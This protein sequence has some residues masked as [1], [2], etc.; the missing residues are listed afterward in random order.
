METSKKIIVDTIGADKG[1]GEVVG[2]ALTALNKRNDFT[3]VL[4]GPENEINSHLSSTDLKRTNL[5]ILNAEEKITNED[6]PVMA[7]R[8]K[9]NSSMVLSLEALKEGRADGFLSCGSTGALLAGGTLKVGRIKG[10]K[11]AAL[12]LVVPGLNK[13]TI[14]L[15]VGANADCTPLWLEQFALMGESYSELLFDIQN[16]KIG[17]LNIGSE[18]GKGN[19]LSKETYELFEK[20]SF[21]FI[22]NIEPKEILEND[23]DVLVCD[24][25][26]GNLVL[27]TFE[28]TAKTIKDIL[29]DVILSSSKT[30]IAG[31]LLKGSIKKSISQL[32][33]NSIGA[34][35]L[36]GIKRPVFK[37]HGSSDKS[38]IEYGVYN[39]LKFIDGNVIGEIEKKV[40]E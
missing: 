11:R 4:S 8:T 39:L 34:A 20:S 12:T 22:G 35:P 5:E 19:E 17:L 3:L 1:V 6:E 36:L 37:A 7:I 30:K 13:P 21:N 14:M 16:P 9:K 23:A 33:L 26:S 27:K 29:K 18:K 28:G 32:D 40:V 25:F 31:A 38:A 2:G 15:D 10:I 24:G